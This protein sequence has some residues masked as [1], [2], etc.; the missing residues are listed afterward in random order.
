MLQVQRAEGLHRGTVYAKVWV[1]GGGLDVPR[2]KLS[3]V[4]IR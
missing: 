1:G 4:A 3:Y 2:E